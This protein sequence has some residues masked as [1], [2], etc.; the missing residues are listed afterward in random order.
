MISTTE[1]KYIGKGYLIDMS[2]LTLDEPIAGGTGPLS[3]LF[4]AVVSISKP[5]RFFIAA[6]VILAN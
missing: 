4:A 5:N 2:Y 1:A 6:R 3:K